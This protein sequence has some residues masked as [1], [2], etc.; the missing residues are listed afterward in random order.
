MRPSMIEIGMGHAGGRS[1]RMDVVS[2]LNQGI[3]FVL[4]LV[5]LKPRNPEPSDA[6][7]ISTRIQ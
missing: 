7:R 3:L 5:S 6:W 1:N 2:T 4:S